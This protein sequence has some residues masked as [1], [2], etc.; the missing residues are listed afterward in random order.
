[1]WVYV[2]IC[3]LKCFFTK[4]NSNTEVDLTY[5]FPSFSAKVLAIEKNQWIIDRQTVRHGLW[6]VW[7]EF[8]ITFN[9]KQNI[10]QLSLNVIWNSSQTY[11]KLRL[12][13]PL[14]TIRLN[15]FNLEHCCWERSKF[16]PSFTSVLKF[17]F[18]KNTTSEHSGKHR[19]TPKHSGD[20]VP[21]CS[22]V[23][24]CVPMW[25]FLQSWT[26]LPKWNLRQIYFILSNG[27][28]DWKNSNW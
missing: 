13:I 18:V 28:R 1:M 10:G 11:P 12:T 19:H 23:F 4:W 22:Y 27:A 2:L 7:L 24:R 20:S 5:K 26:Q 14:L 25:C 17:S 16:I 3:V 21:V 8:H 9:C 6:Y 15:F